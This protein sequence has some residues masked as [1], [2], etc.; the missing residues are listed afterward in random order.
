MALFYNTTV[1]DRLGLD[2]PTTWDEYRAAAEAIH[3]ADPNAY[4]AADTGDAGFT[5]SM[6]WAAGGKP[7]T[8]DGENVAIDFTDAGTETFSSFWNGLIEDGLVSPASGWSTEWFQGLTNG[9]IATLTTGAWMAGNL[10]SGAPD[11][12]G[13]WRVAAMPTFEARKK[14][15][16]ENGGGGDVIL[17]QSKNKLVAAA[18][19]KWMNVTDGPAISTKMGFFPA[20][21]SVQESE[22]WLNT[23]NDYFGGQEINKVFAES[24]GNVVE[25]W[26]FLPYNAYA[27]S[28][29]N[30]TVGGAYTGSETLQEGL[31]KWGDDLR[32]YG[33]Q[34]GFTVK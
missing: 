17:E 18:F 22:E 26:Q 30:D 33:E 10:A 6:I 31:E 8:V 12:A 34:Q 28:I 13:D 11:A 9:S 5:N 29:F 20:Q 15:S 21:T 7:Y 16:A 32:S 1:F 3:A 4:I 23:K 2:I 27:S 19:L 25:G 14:A 24:A